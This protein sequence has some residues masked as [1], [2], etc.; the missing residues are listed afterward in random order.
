MQRR[1]FVLRVRGA[2]SL[3]IVCLAVVVVA[4]LSCIVR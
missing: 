3:R 1:E 4:A 2:A